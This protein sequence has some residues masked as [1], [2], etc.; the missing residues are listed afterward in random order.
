MKNSSLFISVAVA[1][2]ATSCDS[3]KKP[4]AQS[5]SAEA[6]VAAEK[7]IPLLPV[8]KGDTWNYKVHLEIPAGVSSPGAAEVDES[9]QRTRTYLGKVSAA[10]GLPEVDCFEVIVPGS[11]HERE[12]VEIRDDAILMRGSMIM[13]PDTTQP[14]WLS[15][16]VPFVV[17]GMKAGT[18]SP[19]ISA[20]SGSLT[21][22]T[23]VVAREV[24]KVPAGEF[25]T[26]R[27]LMTGMDGELELRRTTWFAPGTGIVR[28]EKTR[29]RDGKVIFRE[30][31][32][33][34][35]TSIKPTKR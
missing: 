32:E 1:L 16:P 30:T 3:S 15:H 10:N 35:A 13:R 6:T 11:P 19:D 33:L 14:M 29:Y 26:I 5:P 27:L 24:I 8:T 28:E 22:K 17:A 25:P 34:T 9:F 12:F 18:E 31:Q 21:R 23:R 20:P 4:A 7:D 2:L